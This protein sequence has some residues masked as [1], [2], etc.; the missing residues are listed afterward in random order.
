MKR[1]WATILLDIR[2][3][4]AHGLHALA[5]A[6][7]VGWLFVFHRYPNGLGEGGAQLLPFAICFSL[8][9]T[10][11]LFTAIELWNQRRTLAFQAVS[12]TPL[13]PHEYLAAKLASLGGLASA[14]CLILYLGTRGGSG[15][16]LFFLVLGASAGSSLLVLAAVLALAYPWLPRSWGPKSM[17]GRSFLQVTIILLFLC[18]PGMLSN[19]PE[20]GYPRGAGLLALL[21]P[22]QGVYLLLSGAFGP[23]AAWQ[24]TYGILSTGFWTALALAFCPR[25]FARLRM[26]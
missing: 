7:T 25:G 18:L 9:S 22:A 20:P 4:Y 21:L 11:Y 13:R 3:Q 19:D 1:V 6:I 14:Q 10:A 26:D 12:V 8:L 23:I 2:M 5:L 24:W 16:E 17:S 15:K